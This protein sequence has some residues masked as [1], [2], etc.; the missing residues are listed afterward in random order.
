MFGSIVMTLESTKRIII[1]QQDATLQGFRNPLNKAIGVTETAYLALSASAGAGPSWGIHAFM[2]QHPIASGVVIVTLSIAVIVWG[3]PIVAP[4][5]APFVPQAIGGLFGGGI[6]AQNAGATHIPTPPDLGKA[7]E[8]ISTTLAPDSGLVANLA[9]AATTAVAGVLVHTAIRLVDGS[10]QTEEAEVPPAVSAAVQTEVL[11]VIDGVA[12]TD[13]VPIIDGVSQ[14]EVTSVSSVVSQT[15]EPVISAIEHS[16]AIQRFVD[17]HKEHQLM[18]TALF[19]AFKGAK[20]SKEKITEL[21]GLL[22]GLASRSADAM[23]DL[24]NLITGDSTGVS[25]KAI[26]E[27]SVN[28]T[29]D[30]LSRMLDERGNVSASVRNDLIMQARGSATRSARNALDL[31]RESNSLDADAVITSYNEWF[32]KKDGA[33]TEQIAMSARAVGPLAGKTDIAVAQPALGFYAE[34]E[35][36]AAGGAGGPAPAP[37]RGR[38]LNNFLSES[39]YRN[40][41]QVPEEVHA[42]MHAAFKS[43]LDYVLSVKRAKAQDVSSIESLSSSDAEAI[44]ETIREVFMIIMYHF[45]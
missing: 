31:L 4:Y 26:I 34:L 5:V 13:P 24:L 36:P 43:I 11:P 7:V 27:R 3:G 9:E 16:R 18:E 41:S 30:T 44:E 10:T 14:T 35:A 33:A 40:D 32:T 45:Y 42:K 37:L 21:E 22:H 6:G 23:R 38:A 12:Q 8:H 1:K 29:L 39:H 20:E 28:M 19:N 15:E 2:E 17:A 25:S